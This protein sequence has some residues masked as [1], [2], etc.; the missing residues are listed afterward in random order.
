MK[1]IFSDEPK[2]FKLIYYNLTQ[3]EQWGSGW[4]SGWVLSSSLEKLCVREQAAPDIIKLYIHKH[5]Y[6][7]FSNSNCLIH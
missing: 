5:T 7:R 2:Y 3:I 6:V 4:N 1:E